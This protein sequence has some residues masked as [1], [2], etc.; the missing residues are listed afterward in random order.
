M[1]K[2]YELRSDTV[3][4]DITPPGLSGFGAGRRILAVP[5]AEVLF[6]TVH[7]SEQMVREALETGARGYVLKSDAG[8]DLLTAVESVRQHR[9]FFSPRVTQALG[10]GPV[11]SALTAPKAPT[12]ALT[13]REREILKLLAEGKTIKE[14][15][16]VLEIAV[17]TA[18]THRTNIMRKLDLHSVSDLVRYAIRNRIVEP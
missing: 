4:L 2:A 13:P 11:T 12:S 17:K 9:F 10:S 18:E 6:L 3:L 5:H 8:R 15:A 16:V 1:Q 14:S 7:D